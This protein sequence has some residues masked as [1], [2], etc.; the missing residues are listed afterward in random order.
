[1]KSSFIIHNAIIIN[2]GRT[3]HGYLAVENGF[4]TDVQ[5]G[6]MPELTAEVLKQTDLIDAGG[7]YLM[8]GV[9]DDQVHFRE[10]GLTHKGD[11]FTESRAAVAGGITSY[12]EMPNT[13]P[14][15]ITHERLLE[16]HAIAAQ[17]SLANYAF[18]LGA[19][20]ENIEEIKKVDP[21]I[22]P[23]IKVFMGAST[24]NMLV[25]DEEVLEAIF[26][27][28][29][30]LVAIHSEDETIIRAN[31]E[32][33]KAQYGQEVPIA[34]HPLIRSADAC[35][36]STERAMRIAK[37]YNT[38]LHI[39]HLSTAAELELLSKM[40]FSDDKRITA[41]VC[42][43]HLWFDDHDYDKKGTLIKW[44]PAIKANTDREALLNALLD[45]RLD[46][47]ATDH[48]PHTLEEKSH[49]YFKAPSG[50]PLVQH[51]LSLMFELSRQG[52]ISPEQIVDKMC[53]TMARCFGVLKRGYLRKGYHADLVIV[54]PDRPWT[55]SKNN[56]LYKC[57]WSPWEGETLHA[58]ITHTFVNGHLAWHDGVI[59]DKLTGQP[60][61][62]NG[63]SAS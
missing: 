17:H 11:I 16:K 35:L 20:N 6:S 21:S 1:M 42:V 44:N 2:E 53:H 51:A 45:N 15:T 56:I 61:Q 30:I 40:P 37:K 47:I 55:I 32:T 41:E 59:D 31:T 23:G 52:K 14:Q 38:R 62:F 60:L 50:G 28:S 34:M 48:A 10:P 26:R 27:E 49:T 29:P 5:E 22:T 58:A 36:Q 8:P 54:N 13:N 24:G 4:I 19:T 57:G 43:H 9:I 39:L 46:V 33:Y 7:A 3:F 12:M 25:D 63:K 18:Y